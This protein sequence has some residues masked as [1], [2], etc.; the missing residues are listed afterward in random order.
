MAGLV[1]GTDYVLVPADGSHGN[2]QAWDVRIERGPYTETVLRYGNIKADENNGCLN[3][4][5]MIQS[6]PS[7]VTTE[8]PEM[9]EYAGLVLESLLES[10][11]EDG[12]LQATSAK[13]G[14]KEI[15]EEQH[16]NLMRT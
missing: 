3:F 14:W 1:E 12:S 7:E 10:A 13:D 9:Q 6:S 16:D 5:F 8:D 4:S 15:S 2:D 11:A